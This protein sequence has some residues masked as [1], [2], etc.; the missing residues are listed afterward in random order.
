MLE[1]EARCAACNYH[2]EPN[3]EW[4]RAGETSE[5]GSITILRLDHG[6]KSCKAPGY[7]STQLYD[8][9]SPK[10]ILNDFVADRSTRNF[11]YP[12]LDAL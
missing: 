3:F 1:G 9:G 8:S 12:I 11:S 6:S 10:D 7:F 2:E 5:P 4:K